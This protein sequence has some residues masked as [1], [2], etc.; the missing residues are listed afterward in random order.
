MRLH[1]LNCEPVDVLHD[2][3]TRAYIAEK[4]Q[5]FRGG[6]HAGLH[7]EPERVLGDGPRGEWLRVSWRWRIADASN[8]RQLKGVLGLVVLLP[9]ASAV[10]GGAGGPPF[11]LGS[12]A[13]R[14]TPS[15]VGHIVRWCTAGAGTAWL[16]KAYPMPSAATDTWIADL[17]L[18]AEHVTPRLRRGRTLTCRSNP[19]QPPL[20]QRRWWLDEKQAAYA[21]VLLDGNAF[22]GVF[23]EPGTSQEQP[24][25]IEGHI[26]DADLL[27]IVDFI[28]S[29][30]WQFQALPS[31]DDQVPLPSDGVESV[32]S[33]AALTRKSDKVFQVSID[34]SERSGQ[35]V[36]VRREGAK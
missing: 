15:D 33:I 31:R 7:S 12:R 1:P 27:S 6:R 8:M 22:N 21:Q 24:F 13:A 2:L 16:V 9:H 10:A 14:L 25:L 11:L 17:Y 26:G 32:G 34:R 36:R 19:P 4:A 30:P 29:S 20:N 18:T 3:Q 23:V 5:L 35:L 28:R